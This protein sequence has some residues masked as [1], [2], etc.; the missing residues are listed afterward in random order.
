VTRTLT[1]IKLRAPTIFLILAA[2]AIPIELVSPG[3]HS[4]VDL[5][6][7]AA[8]GFV[9]VLGFVPVGLV[10]GEFGVL[11]A[12][13]A[14]ALMSGLA[15]TGQLV[16]LYRDASVSDF[17]GN[18][19]GAFLGAVVSAHWK[20]RSP[21]LRINRWTTFVAAAVAL[22]VMVQ[23]WAKQ[24]PGVSRRGTTSPGTLEAY[25]KL[26]EIG[27][28]VAF[29]SSGH[30]L[31]GRFSTESEPISGPMGSSV[32]F[33]GKK[34]YIEVGRSTALRLAGSMTITAWINSSFFPYDDA[35]IVSQKHARSGYQLDT[36]IDKG[37]RTIGFKLSN[38]CGN[39][40]AR[41]GAT[42][43]V[44]GTWYHVAGV[45]DAPKRTLD[46]YLN[47]K[48]DNGPLIGPITSTQHSSRWP[49]YIGR[50]SDLEGF[51]FVGL[52]RNVRIYSFALT[53]E[54][55]AAGMR[56]ES[57]NGAAADRVASNTS[58]A[59]RTTKQNPQ[60]TVISISEEGDQWI[61]VMAACL[62]VLVAVACVGLWPS[63]SLLLYVFSSFAAGL[64]LLP[65]IVPN[66]P[67]FNLWL[68]PLVTL[69]GGV[70]V[71]VSARRYPDSN[72]TE[73]TER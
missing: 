25:W 8:H 56:E 4:T 15:E 27:G 41:Y 17:I 38:V 12:L 47:G 24:G 13:A 10:L 22:A 67:S 62:G 35:A 53:H 58:E 48:L 9:N 65:A 23:V 21:A 60:C 20:I 45:Y 63:A 26:D 29:D 61:P 3:H 50:R 70:A 66:V 5:S 71:V 6:I 72:V 64:L 57:V 69:A 14:A 51:G 43:L 11:R 33:D 49:V 40:M 18:V 2:I 44:V 28:R 1:R 34:E 42:P 39:D 55:I 52:I 73:V 7:N 32:V 59:G 54:E 16:M 68:I 36:T 19:T 30:S 37:A 31:N 46:V